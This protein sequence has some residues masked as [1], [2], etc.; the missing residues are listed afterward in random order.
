MQ[1]IKYALRL[2]LLLTFLFVSA[3]QAQSVLETSNEFVLIDISQ[4]SG[5]HVG[6]KIQIYRKT[7]AAEDSVVAEVEIVQFKDKICAAKILDP[8]FSIRVGDYTKINND[9][10]I[11][12]LFEKYE[13]KAPNGPFSSNSS[14]KK[15]TY[16]KNNTLSYILMGSGVLASGLGVFFNTKADNTYEDYKDALTTK[17]MADLYDETTRYDKVAQISMGIGGGLIVL[18]LVKWLFLDK[19]PAQPDQHAFRVDPVTTPTYAGLNLSF[20]LHRLAHK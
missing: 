18:G 2:T 14:P 1:N 8:N 4:S 5:L 7:T 9:V 10:A 3:G 13:T 19:T 20:D 12:N 16:Q 11:K 6:D 17:R 15:Q